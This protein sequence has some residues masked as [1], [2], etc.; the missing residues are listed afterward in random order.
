MI[1]A[2]ALGISYL[3]Y[4]LF[5]FFFSVIQWDS[6]MERP[7]LQWECLFVSFWHKE[8]IEKVFGAGRRRIL[9]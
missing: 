8:R 4:Y 6:S 3:K 2:I 5:F 1:L 7:V 9:Y